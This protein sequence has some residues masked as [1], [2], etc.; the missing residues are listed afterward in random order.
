MT[1]RQM[2]KKHDLRNNIE[3]NTE[4][5]PKRYSVQFLM[6]FRIL[7]EKIDLPRTYCRVK[8][9]ITAKFP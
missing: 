5:S 3:L 1:R 4:L 6:N 2:A 7:H 9:Q 8:I